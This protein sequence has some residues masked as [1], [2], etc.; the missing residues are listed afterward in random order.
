MVSW[1]L[2]L[3]KTAPAFRLAPGYEHDDLQAMF[4]ENEN[5]QGKTTE[6][7]SYFGL[8]LKAKNSTKKFPAMIL[9]HGGGGTAFDQWVRLWNARGYAAIT[10]DQCGFLPHYP[11]S[12][13]GVA[14]ERNPNGGPPGWDASFQTPFEPITEQW[15]YHAISAALR[16]HGFLANHPS[17]DASR[18]GVTGISWGG[19]MTSVFAGVNPQLACAVP[20]YGC[21]FLGQSSH[22]KWQTFPSLPAKNV[23]RWLELWDPSNFLPNAKCP[24]C[25]V[26]GSNDFAYP[27]DALTA[28]SNLPRTPKI[29]SIR[30][31]LPHSHVEG[32]APAEIYTFVDSILTGGQPLP[33]VKSSGFN[34]KEIWLEFDPSI[35]VSRAEINYTRATGYLPD[36]KYNRMP[37]EIDHKTGRVQCA[38]PPL[39][40]GA[41]LNVFDA[42]DH[43]VSGDAMVLQ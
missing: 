33:R 12:K 43:V 28:S 2:D 29:L 26:S 31:E 32:W 7:F 22:W 24:I 1:N 14:R 38:I 18:I 4:I 8:P 42:Q 41:F 15:V 30:H 27:V 6:F 37:V 40:T 10:L 34:E 11:V 17:I 25:W 20:V 19:F 21:G 36:R 39:T 13:D 23:Q 16:C 35:P 5:Y 3:L 9:L